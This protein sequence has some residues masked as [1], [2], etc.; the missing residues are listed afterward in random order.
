MKDFMAVQVVQGSHKL[1][2]EVEESI[3][4]R[5]AE[6]L[7]EVLEGSRHIFH[8]YT[9]L[10]RKVIV[11]EVSYYVFMVHLGEDSDL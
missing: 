2:G 10:V 4:G 1:L 9:G 7:V 6:I 5:R 3:E 11:L 8:E